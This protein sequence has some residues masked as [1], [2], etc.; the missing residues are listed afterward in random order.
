M[1]ENLEK[2]ASQLNSISQQIYD[3]NKL[4]AEKEGLVDEE[5]DDEGEEEEPEGDPILRDDMDEDGEVPDEEE[6]EEEEDDDLKKLEDEE[7]A[8]KQKIADLEIKQ[9]SSKA[10]KRSAI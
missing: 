7:A 9:K 8:L 4:K 1:G 6:E 5:D 3:A 2:V 10:K